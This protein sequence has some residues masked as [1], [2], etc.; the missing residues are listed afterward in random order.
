MRMRKSFWYAQ[1]Q[2]ISVCAGAGRFGMR[3]RRSFRYA[4]AQVILVCA[5]AG[6]FAMRRRKTFFHAQAQVNFSCAGAGQIF[7]LCAG[8]FFGNLLFKFKLKQ[9]LNFF[10]G[11]YFY[12]SDKL[13]LSFF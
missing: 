7:F 3:R 10:A 1:A 4:Q 12:I 6:H 8:H 11:T 13:Q 5:G 2:V 9:I